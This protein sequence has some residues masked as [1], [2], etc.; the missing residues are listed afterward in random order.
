[1]EA[2]G[3]LLAEDEAVCVKGRLDAREDR[4]VFIAMGITPLELSS[5]QLAELR[6]ALPPTATDESTLDALKNILLEHPGNARVYLQAGQR[7]WR[8]PSSFSVELKPGLMGE[9][10]ELLGASAVQ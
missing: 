10:R 6:V 1:M 4:T 8:L 9:L 3:S 5:A 2:R 7:I